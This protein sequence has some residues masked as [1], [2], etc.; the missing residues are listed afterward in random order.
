MTS[1]ELSELA[2]TLWGS[3]R[4]PEL[5]KAPFLTC[6]VTLGKERVEGYSENLKMLHHFL[7]MELEESHLDYSTVPGALPVWRDRIG[8]IHLGLS[9]FP[10]ISPFASL[11][12]LPQGRSRPSRKPPACLEWGEGAQ[13]GQSS[14]RTRT[15]RKAPALTREVGPGLGQVERG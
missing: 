8:D 11:C 14:L 7:Q 12:S 9:Q 4:V 15:G 1:G 13:H 5:E 2:A 3:P 10:C 6:W